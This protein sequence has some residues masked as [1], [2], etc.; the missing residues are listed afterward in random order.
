M[1]NIEA[2]NMSE[3][4]VIITSSFIPSHP[5]TKIID[6]TLYSLKFISADQNFPIILAHDFSDKKQYIEYLETIK[7]YN[8][9]DS[10]ISIYIRSDHGHLVGNIRNII[11]KISTRY[12]LVV[13]HDLPF[14]RGFEI[15]KI[16]EDMDEQL[17][18]KCLR[19]NKRR[20]IKVGWDRI[21]NIFGQQI[22]CKNYTYTRTPAWSDNNHLCT[23]EYYKDIVLAE[24]KDGTAMEHT[25]GQKAKTESGHKK[26]GPYIFGAYGEEN[27]IKHIDGRHTK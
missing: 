18:I 27:V 11:D 9:K 21:S 16:I 17:E 25:L 8:K 1:V 7:D 5:S 26:Y 15:N 10:R 2:Y 4:T 23:T 12:I 24:C 3:F 14:V 19:F 13:Q 6:R 20:N 22:V